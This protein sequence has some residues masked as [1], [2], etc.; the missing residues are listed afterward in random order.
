MTAF[1]ALLR[2]TNTVSKEIYDFLSEHKLTASRF[3][4]LEAI[5]KNGPLY[6][7]D[8][9][10]YIQKTTGNITTVID[11]LEKQGL[12]ERVRLKEDR[13]YFKI[14]LTAR[15]RRVI[16]KLYPSHVEQVDKVMGK[17]TEAEQKELVRICRKLGK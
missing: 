5:K 10:K 6:Q 7:V 11:N 13:R 12:V 17:L 2:S 8:L 1:V 9:A 16:N 15:G 14:V 3:G 4:V